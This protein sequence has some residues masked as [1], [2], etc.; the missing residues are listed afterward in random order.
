MSSSNMVYGGG[1]PQGYPY[2]NQCRLDPALQATMY[3]G[4]MPGEELKHLAPSPHVPDTTFRIGVY[5]TALIQSDDNGDRRCDVYGGHK[6][7]E[8]SVSL[9]PRIIF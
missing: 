6:S 4:L 8:C 9:P 1:I 3:P 2:P 5:G 7:I